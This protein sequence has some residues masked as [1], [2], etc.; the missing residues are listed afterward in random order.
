MEF[1]IDLPTVIISEQE[2]YPVPNSP[3]RSRLRMRFSGIPEADSVHL[4]A[5]KLLDGEEAEGSDGLWATMRVRGRLEPKPPAVA[6][7]LLRRFSASLE[8]DASTMER[9]YKEGRL[10]ECVD[11]DLIMQMFTQA[12]YQQTQSQLDCVEVDIGSLSERFVIDRTSVEQAIRA[13]TLEKLVVEKIEDLRA[14][15]N[16]SEGILKEHFGYLFEQWEDPIDLPEIPEIQKSEAHWAF[17]PPI[18]EELRRRIDD[19]EYYVEVSGEKVQN[20]LQKA[21]Q[22]AI[23]QQTTELERTKELLEKRSECEEHRAK[24]NETYSLGEVSYS[25][26]YWGSAVKFFEGR[27]IPDVYIATSAGICDYQ[28]DRFFDGITDILVGGAEKP[29]EITGV[30][31]G[32]SGENCSTYVAD[33]IEKYIKDYLQLF[34][35]EKLTDTGVVNAIR[36]ALVQLSRDY[37]EG[38]D[39]TTAI[40]CT[41]IDNVLWVANIGDSRALLIEESTGYCLQL[42]DDHKPEDSYYRE[43]IESLGGKVL[44]GRVEGRLAMARA[45]G[46]HDQPSVSARAEIAKYV[47][48]PSKSYIL[49]EVSDGITAAMT[50]NHIAHFIDQ[51]LKQEEPLKEVARNLVAAAVETFNSDDN[52]TVLIRKIDQT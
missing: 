13:G 46:D 12:G 9:A 37:A 27:A 1:S 28:E 21:I 48:D 44:R 17:S 20:E 22:R 49:V 45:I 23:E 39:G 34:N 32:H 18:E 31:D 4:I 30:F 16:P 50:T 24:Y 36:L 42:S 14:R 5:C 10:E 25:R 8:I 2:A 7:A 38:Q 41:K 11:N 33:N 51:R 43:G 29:I 26:S 6:Q 19:H 3:R 35:K 47:L 40:V 52:A 15:T